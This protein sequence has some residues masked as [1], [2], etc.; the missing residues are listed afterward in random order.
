MPGAATTLQVN[1]KKVSAVI[2]SSILRKLKSWKRRG[3]HVHPCAAPPASLCLS[4]ASRP[5]SL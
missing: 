3:W 4:V 1:M 5:S 2:Y